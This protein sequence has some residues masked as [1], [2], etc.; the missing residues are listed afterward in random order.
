MLNPIFKENVQ[1]QNIQ[2]GALNQNDIVR[3]SAN[4]LFRKN[5]TTIKILIIVVTNMIK[6]L[7]I[8]EL[9]KDSRNDSGAAHTQNPIL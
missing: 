7:S 2:G 5:R 3:E 6:L 9:V 1:G 8:K 4:V